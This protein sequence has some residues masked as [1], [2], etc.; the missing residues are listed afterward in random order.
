MRRFDLGGWTAFSTT[1]L[2]DE[3]LLVIVA[4]PAYPSL[5]WHKELR[6]LR[7]NDGSLAAY[8]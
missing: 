1:W 4:D 7:L 5:P 3:S 6:T 8:P 2:D